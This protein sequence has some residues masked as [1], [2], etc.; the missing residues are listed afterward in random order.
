[1]ALCSISRLMWSKKIVSA[2]GAVC[3]DRDAKGDGSSPFMLFNDGAHRWWIGFGL[4]RFTAPNKDPELLPTVPPPDGWC[5]HDRVPAE[6]VAVQALVGGDDDD[7]FAVRVSCPNASAAGEYFRTGRE[8]GRDRWEKGDGCNAQT[9]L[10]DP[11]AQA[12]NRRVA[13]V[14]HRVH[15][16]LRFLLVDLARP[17]CLRERKRGRL[18]THGGLAPVPDGGGWRPRAKGA[19]AAGAAVLD[20]EA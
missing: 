13:G 17:L 3:E 14:E 8:N 4:Y 10:F 20:G 12:A 6:G 2:D 19:G 1:M 18:T 7:V 15:L 9:S 16:L 5:D 11:I